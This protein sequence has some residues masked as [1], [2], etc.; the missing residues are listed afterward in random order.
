VIAGERGNI[1]KSSK[2]RSQPCLRGVAP[3]RDQFSGFCPW[4][5][6]EPRERGED[7]HDISV[8]VLADGRIEKPIELGRVRVENIGVGH[9]HSIPWL[10]ERRSPLFPKG[11]AQVGPRALTQ[12]SARETSQGVR[13]PRGA[14]D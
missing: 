6:A 14:R 4:I 12:V 2:Q 5:E 7:R 11:Y 3:Q 8:P 13:N 10:Q 9:C 1:P